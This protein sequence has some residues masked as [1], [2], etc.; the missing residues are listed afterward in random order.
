[1]GKS[2]YQRKERHR[3]LERRQVDIRQQFGRHL[4]RGQL[5]IAQPVPR[6]AIP[7]DRHE[8]QEIL[9]SVLTAVQ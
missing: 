3:V 9:T 8:R 6:V 1:M 5:V 4:H 7:S 2:G